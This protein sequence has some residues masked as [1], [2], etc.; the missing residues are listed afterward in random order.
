MK[1]SMQREDI[2]EGS[3]QFQTILD[4]LVD[5]GFQQASLESEGSLLI[6]K[7]PASD[8]N[9]LLSDSAVRERLV[10]AVR[11]CGFTRVALELTSSD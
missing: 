7:L 3:L 11:Q 9:R 8:R 4:W 6:I 10:T 5:H 2:Q 1:K